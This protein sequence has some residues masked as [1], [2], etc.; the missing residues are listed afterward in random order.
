MMSGMIAGLILSVC[1][2]GWA[3]SGR[4]LMGNFALFL[5]GVY[6]LAS[7][8]GIY[9]IGFHKRGRLIGDVL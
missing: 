1:Y 5:G 4:D 9:I 3:F 6:G 8:N 2:L 7:L